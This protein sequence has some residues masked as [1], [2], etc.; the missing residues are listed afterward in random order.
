MDVTD[1]LVSGIS[2]GKWVLRILGVTILEWQYILLCIFAGSLKKTFADLKTN[3]F[4][5][6]FLSESLS[7]SAQRKI[8]LPCLNVF[9]QFCLLSGW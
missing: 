4:L 1:K 3:L 8:C 5:I 7:T 2:N 9:L 6:P